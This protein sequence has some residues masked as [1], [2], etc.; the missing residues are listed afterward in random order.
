MSFVAKR[1]HRSL[2]VPVLVLSLGSLVSSCQTAPDAIVTVTGTVIGIE[3]SQSPA[4]SSPSATI[5]YKRAEYAYVPIRIRN[6]APEETNCT[7]TTFETPNVLTELYFKS[8]LQTQL[9]QRLAIGETAVGQGGA[10]IIFA[11]GPDGKVDENAVEV[12]EATTADPATA[13]GCEESCEKLTAFWEADATTNGDLIRQ[14]MSDNGLQTGS[15][16]LGQFI[17]QGKFAAIRQI[18]VARLEL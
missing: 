1:V 2:L 15:G 9:Y 16:R 5:G 17:N 3:G 18:C 7:V 6:C 10:A 14:C 8:L 12:L 4:S 11:R 13:Y